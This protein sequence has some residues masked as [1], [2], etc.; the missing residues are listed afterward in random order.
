MTF[1]FRL[2][3]QDKSGH[4]RAG[5]ISADS[6]EEARAFLEQNE[7]EYA[8]FTLPDQE[9]TAFEQAEQEAEKTGGRAAADVRSRLA[10][11]R[12]AQPYKLVKLG[13]VK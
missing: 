2:E 5:T 6:K 13:E 1:R 4:Y 11:H 7:A 10:L 9:R 8:S 12:Q 3:A